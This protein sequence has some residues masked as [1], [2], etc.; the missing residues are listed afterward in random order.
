[1]HELAILQTPVWTTTKPVNLGFTI[2]LGVAFP[3]SGAFLNYK[4][5]Q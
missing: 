3:G 1:M 2:A 4:A 5:D